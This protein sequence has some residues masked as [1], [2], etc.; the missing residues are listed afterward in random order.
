[1][2]F[3]PKNFTV[4][5]EIPATDINRAV[6]F[7]SAVF[8]LD[9]SIDENGPNP[10]AMFPEKES[11]SVSGHIYTGKPAPEGTGPTI[12]F[13]CPD[14]LEK[15]MERITQAGGKVISEIITIPNGKFF[16]G[17][18]TEGNSIGVFAN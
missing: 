17:L 12:H 8:N 10:M 2:S 16:Y 7:Y 11:D 4:W 5:S 14:D 18:D 13:A 1:M 3:N 9:L 15:T 6:T